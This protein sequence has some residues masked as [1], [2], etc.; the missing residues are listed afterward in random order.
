M[1][2]NTLLIIGI[3][4]FALLILSGGSG[5]SSGGL[6]SGLQDA[7]SSV[8]YSSIKGSNKY[9][10]IEGAQQL[11]IKAKIRSGY[12]FNFDDTDD[13]KQMVAATATGG[14]TLCQ[15]DEL[16]SDTLYHFNAY[17][18]NKG[19]H[20]LNPVDINRNNAPTPQGKR[21]YAIK[22]YKPKENDISHTESEKTKVGIYFHR[23]M[24]ES[25]ANDWYVVYRKY[26]YDTLKG[27]FD[28]GKKKIIFPYISGGTEYTINQITNCPWGNRADLKKLRFDGGQ[29]IDKQWTFEQIHYGFLY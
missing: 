6:L 22:I 28:S 4:V 5:G 7:V 11:T 10:E 2:T 20:A 26:D 12:N 3:A 25:S 19:I 24:E 13:Y 21:K 8:Q 14:Y 18:D 23:Y 17:K 9:Y 15:I 27:E 1:N 29:V 16:S